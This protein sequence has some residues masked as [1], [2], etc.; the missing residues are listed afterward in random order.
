MRG[1]LWLTWRQHR[2][3]LCSTAVVVLLASWL[4]IE[5]D[6][7]NTPGDAVPLSGFYAQLV[8]TAFGGLVGMFWGAPLVAREF[9]ER[10]YLVAWGQDVSPERWLA[11]K[12]ALLGLV[13]VLLAVPIGLGDGYRG[14]QDVSWDVFEVSPL[15]QAGYVLFGL[16]AGV[17]MSAL[18][19]HTL[20]SMGL[21]LALYVAVRMVMSLGA[22][23]HYLPTERVLSEV[24]EAR[25]L[26]EGVQIVETGYLD[27][28]GHVM[29][30][31]SECTAFV[32]P[33]NC[34]RTHGGAHSF[35][36]FQPID[37]LPGFQVAEFFAFTA[38]A[39]GLFFL[40]FLRLRRGWRPS[41][42]HRRIAA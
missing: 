8:Q 26:P 24:G 14:H 35:V 31:P 17:L 1:L 28:D 25:Q 41:R 2:W 6:L 38:F 19:R 12:V 33:Q 20:T 5:L 34:I 3:V 39:A 23:D 40:A 22:R 29:G 11:G 21:T 13:A 10:T 27:G 30:M 42:S 16:A 36:D 37:R 7:A 18:V 9:E 32:N 15:V 4:L